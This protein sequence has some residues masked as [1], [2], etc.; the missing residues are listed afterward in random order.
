MKKNI[1]ILT[2]N[3]IIAASYSI[4]TIL[5]LLI[6]SL[7]IYFYGII[8]LRISE[9]LC[10]I[11]YFIPQSIW[12]LF[13]GCIITNIIG[14]FFGYSSLIDILVGPIAT[15]IAAYL[16][17]KI[18]KKW[19]IPLPTILINSIIIGTMTSI[20]FPQGNKNMFIVYCIICIISVAITESITC[21][22]LGKI[23]YNIFDKNID[24][25]IKK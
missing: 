12:G 2:L 11:P 6:P 5:P 19:M 18:K 25:F 20:L 10:V 7:G 15:L 8:Q 14:S 13:L 23:V 17:T 21:Y 3:G 9:S 22:T 1:L 16:T 24:K 4:L